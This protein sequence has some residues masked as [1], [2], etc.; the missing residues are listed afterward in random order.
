MAQ[1]AGSRSRRQEAEARAARAASERLFKIHCER[2]LRVQRIQNLY[3]REFLSRYP[4][5]YLP[6][7]PLVLGGRAEWER[8]YRAWR[9]A[10]VLAVQA[11]SV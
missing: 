11:E 1:M 7:P 8:K 2:A 4:L 6:I 3:Y 5:S 9:D 10:V